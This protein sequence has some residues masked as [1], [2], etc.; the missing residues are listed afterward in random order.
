MRTS[1]KVLAGVGMMVLAI[2]CIMSTTA[3]IA[4]AQTVIFFEDFEGSPPHPLQDTVDENPATEVWSPTPPE[5]WTVDNSNMGV[6]G[7]TEF[8]GFTFVDDDWWTTTAGDQGRVN[9]LLANGSTICVGESDEWDDISHTGFFESY[10]STK[11]IDI[12]GYTQLTLVFDSSWDYEDNQWANITVSYDGD[13]PVEVLRWQS[14]STSEYYKGQAY[15]ETVS[16]PLPIAPP[17]AQ[18]LVITF[19]Y[20]DEGV[21]NDWWW[22]FDNIKV[23]GQ[24]AGLI[25]DPVELFLM[26]EGSTSDTYTVA[27]LKDPND[28]S[29]ENSYGTAT[30]TITPDNDVTVDNGG[31]PTSNPITVTFDDG[32]WNIPQTITVT[33]VDDL[34]IEGPHVSVVSNV[35]TAT[36]DLAL[37]NAVGAVQVYIEDNDVPGITLTETDD[38]TYVDEAGTVIES[39]TVVLDSKMISDNNP[40]AAEPN[41]VNIIVE[42]NQFGGTPQA[43]IQI[44]KVS[45]SGYTTGTIT[46]TFT[47]DNFATPQTIYVKGVQDAYVEPFDSQVIRHTVVDNGT[48]YDASIFTTG[49]SD[50]IVYI[51]DDDGAVF[52]IN[53]GIRLLLDFEDAQLGLDTSGSGANGRPFGDPVAGTGKMGSGL[54]LDGDDYLSCSD[55]NVLRP[56]S[57]IT[58]ASWIKVDSFNPYAA[59]V[60][61]LYDSG[62][63]ESGY[64]LG[65]W[66]GD[67]FTF[68]LV[69]D[70]TGRLTHIEV[71]SGSQNVAQWYHLVGTYNG[72]NMVFYIDGVPV[73]V[74]PRSGNI[75]Y[76]DPYNPDGTFIGRF[77]DNNEDERLAGTVDQTAIWDRALSIAE[78]QTL[79]GAGNGYDLSA[80]AAKPGIIIRES[81]GTTDVSENSAGDDDSYTVEL[82]TTPSATVTVTLEPAAGLD[83]GN[84]D[85]VAKDLSFSAAAAPQTVTVVSTV[86]DET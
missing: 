70:D 19:G 37:L 59:I 5:G 3:G 20:G 12:S 21:G 55:P 76:T 29:T 9:F 62:A 68:G 57:E 41:D 80:L 1:K 42:P 46:L 64:L 73:G 81:G 69:L 32:N 75:D 18:N 33:A 85:G 82:T 49:V 6:G 65:M 27:L 36:T 26:E 60:G 47:K 58:V 34:D 83:V 14:E 40:P 31:G 43:D 13:T 67:R 50:V 53:D 72:A 63:D 74:V 8:Y 86:D 38:W 25:I 17:S 79:Y 16:V 7:V 2:C 24:P 28:G 35:I 77:K 30:V 22:A 44:S 56:T 48:S 61:N 23:T 45:G 66:T 11:E 84:G 54:V 15:N 51:A 39:Y 10:L 4:Q 71:P 52:A 78:V